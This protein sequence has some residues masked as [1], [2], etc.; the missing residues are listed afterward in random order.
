MRGHSAALYTVQVKVKRSDEYRLFGDLD[1]QG[2]YLGEAIIGYTR[3]LDVR[4]DDA[5]SRVQV[6]RASHEEGDEVFIVVTHGQSGVVSDIVDKHDI[7]KAHQDATDSQNVMGAALLRLPRNGTLGW[8]C[9][10]I[11]N[12]RSCKAL[13]TGAIKKRLG[14]DFRWLM[15]EVTPAQIGGAFRAAVNDGRID[16]VKLVRLERVGG[17]AN[18]STDKWV[19]GGVDAKLELDITALHGIRLIP[20][21]VQ[22]FLG[23]DANAFGEILRFEGMTFDA[24]KVRVEL[25][26]GRPRTF[27]I[28]TP[29]AG[30]PITESLEGRLM[31][32]PDGAPTEDSLL[33]ALR[34]MI[35]GATA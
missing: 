9:V 3:E 28:E 19:P 5:T 21:L 16:E 7:L 1:G 2:A 18:A 25:P 24:A 26:D 4:N 23:G 32:G 14:G 29:E 34:S 33:A 35:D 8:F 15:L 10:H 20:T 17:R 30:H 27:N 12:R 31:P 22:R 11:N 13:L 6:Q